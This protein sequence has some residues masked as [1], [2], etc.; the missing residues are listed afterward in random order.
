MNLMEIY[1]D[2]VT[3]VLEAFGGFII[4]GGFLLFLAGL[5]A[6]PHA[7]VFAPAS[8]RLASV[9][10]YAVWHEAVAILALLALSLADPSGVRDLPWLY[11]VMWGTAVLGAILWGS[12]LLAPRE[13][14]IS[15]RG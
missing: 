13:T 5:V 11:G 2:P 4:L 10:K 9:A 6:A 14:G 12:V 8:R 7:R 15:L 1:G 3:N